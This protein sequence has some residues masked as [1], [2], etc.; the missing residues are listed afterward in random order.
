MHVVVTR[1]EDEGEGLSGHLRELGATVLRWPT[2]R[3]SPPVDARPLAEALER[4]ED[5]EWVAFTSARAVEAVAERRGVLPRELRVAAV[6]RSTAAVAESMGWRVRVVPESQTAEGL[7]RALQGAGVGAG[8]RI[9]FPASEIARDT[10]EAGLRAV[11]ADVVRVTAYRTLPAAL[12]A[13]GCARLLEAGQIDAITFTSPSTLEHL[14]LGLGE[15]LW[16]AVAARVVMAAIGPTTASAARSAG[17]VHVIEAADHTLAGLASAI[18]DWARN[19]RP[20]GA[21]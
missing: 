8:T 5:F 9:L 11:G 1:G 16:D 10:L 20:S 17:A 6:G 4:L 12:D 13:H 2:I 18:A 3:T 7:V 19:Q 14:R 15:R 21:S